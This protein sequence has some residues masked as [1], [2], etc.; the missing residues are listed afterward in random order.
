[1]QCPCGSETRNQVHQV[2]TMERALEW[3]GGYGA[4]LPIT[5]D[6]DKCPACGRIHLVVYDKNGRK[7]EERG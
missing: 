5:V 6:Q 3:T 4:K 2:K 7:I 1:M